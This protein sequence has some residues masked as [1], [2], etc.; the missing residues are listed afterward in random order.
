MQKSNIESEKVI[1]K[2]LHTEV[3]K[4]GGF[5]IKL[6]PTFISGL[7]DR[8][9]LYKGSAYFVELKTT[10]KKPRPEQLAVHRRLQGH[11]FE[12]HVID[13]TKGVIDFVN[14]LEL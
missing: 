10:G 12:V 6:L 1:E 4:A 3:V 8:L 5:T 11:D 14:S 2:R 9:V 13:S 7:P